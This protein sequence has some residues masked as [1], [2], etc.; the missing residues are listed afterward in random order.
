MLRI[1]H[2]SVESY[3]RCP[4]LW[5]L[6][7]QMRL[8]AVAEGA[9]RPRPLQFGTAWTRAMEAYWTY[10]GSVPEMLIAA[11]QVFAA[12]ATSLS[13]EDR[14]LGPALLTGYAAMYGDE[15]RL[16]SMPVAEAELT[17]P[18]LDPDGKPDPELEFITIPDTVGYDSQQ[19]TIIVEH[20]TTSSNINNLGFWRRYDRSLQLPTQWMTALDA[21]RPPHELVL[22]VVHAKIMHRG[23]P[24]PIERREFYKRATAGAAVGDPK[25]GTRLTEESREEFESRVMADILCNPGDYYA[26]KSYTYTEQDLLLARADLWA[27]GRGMLEALRSG[28]ATARNNDGCDKYGSTCEFD[29]ACW[30]GADLND[31]NLFQIRSRR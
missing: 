2:S 16:Y 26:R 20:K 15:L 19:R 11:Q 29:A 12:Y 14:V 3:L 23:K 18:V 4:R 1:S 30:S 22:D 6:K 28:G 25:P 10:D 21:G 8:G 31:P 27:A 9:V 13:W 7:H 17:F 24:T 5:L